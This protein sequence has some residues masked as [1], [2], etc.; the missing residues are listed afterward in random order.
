MKA[1]F[2]ATSILTRVLEGSGSALA[3]TVYLPLLAINYPQYRDRALSAKQ[4]GSQFGKSI[5]FVIGGLV[6][7]LLG[8]CGL[9][10]AIGILTL[11]S[12]LIALQ[13]E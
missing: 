11:F 4:C 13:F 12:A 9:F 7:T 2:V 1:L 3:Y 8:Y 6:F 5:G 10:V